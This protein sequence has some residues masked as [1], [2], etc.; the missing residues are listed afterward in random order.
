MPINTRQIDNIDVLPADGPHDPPPWP[1][2]RQRAYP[3]WPSVVALCVFA[4][5]AFPL[6]YWLLADDIRAWVRFGSGSTIAAL[7]PW[8]LI[9]GVVA[10]AVRRWILIEQPGGV[11]VPIWALSRIDGREVLADL[12]DVQQTY[13]G[14]PTRQVRAYT[15]QYPTKIEQPVIE[16]IPTPPA[17]PALP[18]SGGPILM[19]LRQKFA[20]SG[21]HILVGAVGEQ[22]VYLRWKQAGL[23]A[24]IGGSGSGKTNTARL[25]AAWHALNGGGLVICDGHGDMPD[26]SLLHSC[27]S[28]QPSYLL[29][30]AVS[31]EDIYATIKRLDGIGRAR[32]NGQAPPD[33]PILL[34]I[35][36]ATSIFRNHPK[37][38]EIVSMLLNFSDEYRK[39][40]MQ[41]LVIFH[42]VKG[43]TIDPKMGTPLRNGIKTKIVHSIA[44]GEA[45][46]LLTAA[47][48]Q[49]VDRL[50]PGE[51]LFFDGRLDVQRITVPWVPAEALR[52]VTY[53]MH[54]GWPLALETPAEQQRSPRQRQLDDI[55]RRLENEPR[56]KRLQVARQL[57]YRGARQQEIAYACKISDEA[58]G[59]VWRG[60]K[61][62]N[63]VHV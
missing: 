20:R 23:S 55:R 46:M 25:M 10:F 18:V 4:L 43:D 52:E 30:P 56:E 47:E 2:R 35:D 27:Q 12:I 53:P 41:A 54:P 9:F 62:G 16:Q 32:I 34:V 29:A 7:V 60:A 26:E 63:G 24:L 17:L 28:L 13:A 50:Q 22:P 45:K 61:N 14:N 3:A 15:V 51:A 21:E 31:N 57:A 39:A 42:H 40:N 6:G 49:G 1:V 8:L 48:S 5:L 33:V 44:P 36:E 37:A 59:Q 58:A 38:G 11:K 19:Q